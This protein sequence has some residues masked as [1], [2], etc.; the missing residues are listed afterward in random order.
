MKRWLQ[1]RVGRFNREGFTFRGLGILAIV[2]SCLYLL[3][4]WI[5]S[6]PDAQDSFVVIRGIVYRGDI[7]VEAFIAV[8]IIGVILIGLDTLSARKPVTLQEEHYRYQLYLHHRKLYL[9][10][11]FG[12]TAVYDRD[13]ELTQ[14]ER[15]N[16]WLKGPTYISDLVSD[17]ELNQ[18]EYNDR[19][20]KR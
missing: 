1:L 17:I 5:F 18:E 9:N 10:I 7:G 14:E 16:F 19:F 4:K 11:T 3:L 6:I 2:L 8:I 15:E 12:T 20:I 13:I